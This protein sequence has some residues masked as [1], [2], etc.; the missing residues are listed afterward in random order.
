MK[1]LF[2]T[3]IATLPFLSFAQPN[4]CSE[5]VPGCTTPSFP[6]APNNTATNVVDF[7]SGSI[8][9]PSTNPAGFNSGC[10]LSGETSSTFISINVIS[11]GT[12]AWSIIGP[13]GGCFDWIMWQMPNA[14]IAQA[15]AGINGNTL[16][17]VACNWN[18]TCNGNTGMAP[19]GQLPPNGSPS[20]Y[21]NPLPVT[22]GQSYLLCLSNYSGTSQNV[23]LNF[24]GSAGVACGVAAPDQTICQGNSANVTISTPGLSAPQFTWSPTTG[25]SN[26]TGGTNVTVT[27]T[28]TTTYNVQVFQPA[29]LNSS[30]FTGTATFTITVVPP[31]TPNA[32]INDTICLGQPIQLAGTISSATNSPSWQYLTTGISPTPTVT[33]TPNFNTLTPTV[34][35]NQ[36]GVYQFILRESNT[37]CGIVRDT[38]IVLVSNITQTTS[39]VPPSCADLSDG[40]IHINSPSAVEYSFDGGV[41]W[42][43][44]SFA[45][46]FPT[47]TYNVCSRNVHGCQTC[48]NVTIVAPPPM[49]VSVSNDTLICQNGTATMTASAIGG[50]SYLFHWDH[51]TDLAA[52]QAVNPLVNT[53]YT[54]YAENE[55]GC[56]STPE[57][58]VVSVRPP[59][60]GTISPDVTICPGY[61]TTLTATATDGIGAPYVFSWSNGNAYSGASSTI[62]V[63]PPATTIY[64]VTIADECEST[65][66]VLNTTVTVAPLPV[67][68]ILADPNDLCEPA[69]FT[70]VNTT[71]AT[72]VDSVWWTT[73]NGQTFGNVSEITLD[74]LWAG[75]YDV[76]LVV[77]SPQGCIDSTTFYDYLT[78]YPKPF[79][80]LRYSPNPVY[81]FN[82]QVMLTN[83]SLN[84][85]YYQW[86]IESGSPSYSQ[87]ENV[88]TMFPDGQTGEYDV[89]L[90]ATS[91]YNCIDTTTAK[92]VVFPEVLIYAP[93]TFTPDN[94][95]HNQ[96]WGIYI[97]GIDIFD[98]DLYIFNRWGEIIWESHD[99]EALWDG[100]YGG[101]PVQQGTYTW[102]VRARDVQNDDQHEF[103]GFVNVLR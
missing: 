27:P 94:D 91:E 39:S 44:D 21:Q 92:I 29:T 97:E 89:T 95:E 15:C 18:G 75:N 41:T 61:P 46:I 40:E 51:T 6:I 77:V 1:Y 24:F 62:S 55:L 86:F 7:T 33:F 52:T 16:A 20:S 14:S 48:S 98:F 68:Q 37:I 35:V 17:P 79:A 47:G 63:N 72:M 78:V 10:L 81:M 2:I 93:N 53:T 8:S 71:D 13:S 99:P 80:D 25:V 101:L 22:A 4:D 87:Q 59:I 57:S 70:V 30:A 69:I 3:L 42:Q 36:P 85:D 56:L 50:T 12:L 58:I 11:S 103:N 34:M 73:S 96:S 102:I 5:A 66:L 65:P 31:P 38:V 83:Y 60:S 100:T 9:N 49:I 28:Q 64:T 45:V 19:A 74:P 84:A 32:G 76:Q 23:N 26:P 67:P 54:V 43:V 82:T 88:T 90:I